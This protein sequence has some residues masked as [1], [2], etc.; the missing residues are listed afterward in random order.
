MADQAPSVADAPQKTADERRRLLANAIQG[1]VVS[2]H[3]IESQSDYQAVVVKGRPINHILH[4]IL[5]IITAG[6]WGIFVWLPIVAFGGEK[7][8]MVVVDDYGNVMVQKV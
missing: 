3:R 6:L 8:S 1:Q 5:T 2:G 7:R 4:L